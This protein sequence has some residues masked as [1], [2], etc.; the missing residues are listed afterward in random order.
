MI[1]N[2]I[3]DTDVQKK[4]LQST[5]G[6][7]DLFNAYL[8]GL[9]HIDA[10]NTLIRIAGVFDLQGNYEEHIENQ[11]IGVAFVILSGVLLV[12]RWIY[13]YK[14]Q[15][16]QSQR[17][18]NAALY[19]WAVKVHEAEQTNKLNP[20]KPTP[21]IILADNPPAPSAVD[22]QTAKT[23]I[24]KA[25]TDF[26]N[27][28]RDAA[29]L[30]LGAGN[31]RLT[32]KEEDA[33]DAG[34]DFDIVATTPKD[35][36]TKTDKDYGPMS[37]WLFR[38]Q[39]TKF[40]KAADN[41]LMGIFAATMCF[42]AIQWAFF[43]VL[44]MIS[45]FMNVLLP[46][47]P[48]LFTGLAV[49][50]P[51][52]VPLFY[53]GYLLFR[54]F[55]PAQSDPSLKQKVLQALADKL[56]AEKMER[57]ALKVQKELK[58]Q[59]ANIYTGQQGTLST[60]D[61]RIFLQICEIVNLSLTSTSKLATLKGYISE[62]DKSTDPQHKRMLAAVYTDE[63][64]QYADLIT[65]AALEAATQELQALNVATAN[66]K[67]IRSIKALTDKQS[68][69]RKFL[70][71]L[72]T[73]ISWHNAA[74]F[75]VWYMS[76]AITFFA[77]LAGVVLETALLSTPAGII[78]MVGVCL[79]AGA[80]TFFK[81]RQEQIR[82][83]DKYQN[84]LQYLKAQHAESLQYLERIE[85]A[86][87]NK[88]AA[89]ETAEAKLAAELNKN[90]QLRKQLSAEV[91]GTLNVTDV[92]AYQR[93]DYGIANSQANS[94]KV[95]N[96]AGDK[97]DSVNPNSPWTMVK[98][99]YNRFIALMDGFGGGALIVRNYL[100]PGSIVA[101]ILATSSLPPLTLGLICAVAVVVGVTYAT[102]KTWNY[103]KSKQ[104]EKQKRLLEEVTTRVVAAE[105]EYKTLALHKVNADERLKAVT[106]E[107]QQLEQY[108]K[109][110]PPQAKACWGLGNTFKHGSGLF[111][112]IRSGRKS[113]DAVRKDAVRDEA[114]Y[115]QENHLSNTNGRLSS[116]IS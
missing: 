84:K 72:I 100:L 8:D 90:Q 43:Y 87:K 107:N 1:Q 103:Y 46:V 67:E 48:Q 3:L 95:F 20:A 44:P 86:L 53:L 69:R 41:V 58:A 51:L 61:K 49:F 9:C 91:L 26:Q 105:Q 113:K 98:K 30:A 92:T 80:W 111:A 89:I 74:I 36:G 31:Y 106:A 62:W 12:S 27:E 110:N 108:I 15:S 7:E 68:W 35:S 60:E 77:S 47:A 76:T 104:E 25:K 94:D 65:A 114:P 73:A 39:E 22:I 83:T 109:E 5:H 55:K 18:F 85:D 56:A 75:N 59:I 14:L 11:P 42:W 82:D 2:G 21:Q 79:I 115:F 4:P 102:L 96:T 70:I 37:R 88:R 17:W 50:V 54:H 29:N 52:A 81:K 24:E 99:G 45:E 40:Y 97:I 116:R 23:I 10:P 71:P 101:L 66:S 19:A 13:Q 34:L 32:F 93:L 6:V 28:I 63:N 78:V 57:T 16:E 64:I 112:S 38:F 33:K